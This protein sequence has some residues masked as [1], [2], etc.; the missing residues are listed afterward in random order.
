[1]KL[2]FTRL[3]WGCLL[4]LLV[5]QL[6]SAQ[7]TPPSPAP[8]ASGASAR[9]RLEGQWQ[10]PLPVPGGKLEVR[11]AITELANNAY[12][13]SLDVPQQRLNRVPMEVLVKGDTVTFTSAEVGCRFVSRRLPD[14]PQLTGQWEQPG[15]KTA[16]T[17]RYSPLPPPPKNF[18]F[19]P[20]YRIEEVTISVS[21]GTQL[22]GT[23]TTPAGEGPF[24]A[25]VLLSDMGLQTRD[26]PFVDYNLFGSLADYLT[27][28]RVA[29]LR[30]DDRGTGRS[31]GDSRQITTPLRVQDAQAALNFLRTR[32][33]L[34]VTRLGLLGHG[35]GGNVALLAAAQPLPPAFVVSLAATGVVGRE[36]LAYQ[37]A[38]GRADGQP[39][40]AQAAEARR[41]EIAQQ[42]IRRQAEKM[43]ATGANS[44]QIETFLAQQQMR[45]RSAQKKQ[46]EANLKKQQTLIDVVRQTADNTQARAILEN[47]LR[48]FYPE[49]PAAQVLSTAEWMTTPWY[50]Y[51]LDFSPLQGLGGVRCPVLLLHGTEDAQV[52]PATNLPPLE[53]ALKNNGDLTTKRLEGVNHQFQPPMVEWP[54]VGGQSQPVF[55]PL[56]LETIHDWILP[57]TAAAK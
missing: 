27:R 25:V 39:D 7:T 56:A 3:G 43:R 2:F 42:D 9:L 11:I 44:A 37:Q 32:P 48:Q 19:Q 26:A 15:Y 41:Q 24:P 57:P 1:M 4:C 51:Y 50:R 12:F 6:A 33:L 21:D 53:K 31:T 5:A 16:L 13:A 17:L 28:H 29:V 20:P 23:L 34:D 36:H 47:M 18:K 22:S 49:M 8:A 38:L 10:G 52:N 55:S 54:L 46:V 35:E 14:G 30:F 40:T 45:Q